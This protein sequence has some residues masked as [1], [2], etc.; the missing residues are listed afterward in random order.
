MKKINVGFT[1]IELIVVM[2]I[3]AI[4]L[5]VAV[6]SYQNMI[7]K[8]NVESAQE[9]LARSI[10]LAR[11]EAISR[12]TTVSVCRS[13]D[14]ASCAAA[15]EWNQGW[16]V[17]LDND[18]SGTAG[19]VNAAEEILRVY[20]SIP[21]NYGLQGSAAFV[22][23]GNKGTIQLPAAGTPTFEVCSPSD[24]YLRGIMLLRSGR[25]VTSRLDASGDYYI[26]VDNNG[27]PVAISCS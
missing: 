24:D 21:A 22:Q 17:F 2:A 13:A 8:N 16:I 10:A 25:G 20:Q 7:E 18:S 4:L 9:A 23:F 1:L 6:P 11:Q 27:D 3:A 12:N 5:L 26:Q 15:G 14:G 19:V